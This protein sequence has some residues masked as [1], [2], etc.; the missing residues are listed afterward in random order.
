[1]VVLFEPP[2]REGGGGNGKCVYDMPSKRTALRIQQTSSGC[3]CRLISFAKT[4][5]THKLYRHWDKDTHKKAKANLTE[6]I[7][8]NILRQD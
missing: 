8:R 6:K 5:S 1:M 4:T 3:I 2:P 7:K